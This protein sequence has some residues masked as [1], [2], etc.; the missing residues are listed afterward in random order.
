MWCS[1]FHLDFGW[2][3]LFTTPE[4][5]FLSPLQLGPYFLLAM[6][7]VPLAAIYV[8]S[9]YGLKRWFDACRSAS[10]FDPPWAAFSHRAAGRGPVLAVG[11]KP[12]VLAVLSF[13]YSSIQQAMTQDGGIGGAD[14]ADDRAGQDRHHRLDYRQR[15]LRRGFRAS[16]VIGGCGGGELGIVFHRLAGLGSPSGEL[17]DRRHGGLLCRRGQN[18]LFDLDYR[19]RDDRRIR[20]AAAFALGLHAVVHFLRQAIDL[21]LAGGEPG[22]LAGPSRG[23]RAANAGRGPG[24]PVLLAGPRCG[25]AAA[26]R[27][28]DDGA[29]GLGTAASPVLP[30]VD[31]DNRL[32]GVVNL[33]EVHFAAQKPALGS[34]VLVEDLMRTDIRPLTPDDTLDRGLELFVENDLMTL[35]VVDDYQSRH[36]LGMVRRFEIAAPISA[37]CTLRTARKSSIRARPA[38]CQKDGGAR[39]VDPPYT[40]VAPHPSR[41]P[42]SS[43][44]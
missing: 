34:L 42:R 43:M 20:P 41:R 29:R 7:M 3:P 28:L 12:Q 23:F 26:E 5:T 19:Q 40:L 32:L 24:E 38:A 18:A 8:R 1:L 44:W 22:R 2:K 16:M 31:A 33:E 39:C 36:V 35:P 21:F 37:T 10:T 13:G 15:R 25:G 6:F 9:F 4:L 11:K 30:V 27:F 17:R 14:P